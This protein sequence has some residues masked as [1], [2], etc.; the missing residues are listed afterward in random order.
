MGWQ[1]FSESGYIS[2]NP[3]KAG[4]DVYSRNKFN[5]AASDKIASNRDIPDTRLFS[6]NIFTFIISSPDVLLFRL[7]YNAV[8]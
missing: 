5:Q 8:A 3:L 2:G 1:Y 4:E 6:E 7:L